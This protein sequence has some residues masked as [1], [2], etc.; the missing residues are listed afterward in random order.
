MCSE[1]KR[2]K[3]LSDNIT[4]GIS[5]KQTVMAKDSVIT[6]QHVRQ[7]HPHH[8]RKLATLATAVMIGALSNG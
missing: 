3:K 5:V 7:W 4:R 1:K 8:W 6:C 2:S